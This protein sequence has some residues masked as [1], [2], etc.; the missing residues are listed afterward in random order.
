MRQ[1]TLIVVNGGAQGDP[2]VA[3]CVN[4]ANGLAE[5]TLNCKHLRM[6]SV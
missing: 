6:C 4:K 1:I 5:I 2:G 3:H